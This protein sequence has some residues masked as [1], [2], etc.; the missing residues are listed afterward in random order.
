MRRWLGAIL[1]LA[2]AGGLWLGATSSSVRS[3]LD[4]LTQPKLPAAENAAQQIVNT[5]TNGLTNTTANTNVAVSLP[6]EKNLAVPFTSQAPDANWDQDHEE[7]CEEA[8]ILMAA[9]FWQ[10][11]TFTNTADKEAGLQ[12]IKAWELNHLGWYYD[13]T[14]EENAHILREQFGLQV[15]VVLNPTI[16]N[17]KTALAA[18]HPVIVPS[19]GRELGNPNFTAPGPIYHNLIL[20]GYTKNGHFITNDP[21]TRKGE[22]YIYDQSVI[23]NAMHDWVP[24]GDRQRP[25]NGDANGRKVILVVTGILSPTP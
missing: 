12:A 22:A 25:A 23:M 19:A 4:H 7:F 6:S 18:G 10:G 8:A 14:A 13:T 11:K 21:G 5:I 1:V 16:L 2:L 17:I 15:E 24:S 20:R 9:R 3:W